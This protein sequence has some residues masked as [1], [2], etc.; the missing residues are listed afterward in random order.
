MATKIGSASLV[1]P[2]NNV[3]IS[4]ENSIIIIIIVISS[5]ILLSVYLQQ[6]DDCLGVL[7]AGQRLLSILPVGSY[8]WV[9]AIDG[10]ILICDAEVRPLFTWTFP[11]PPD[12]YSFPGRQ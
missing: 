4:E 11:P 10:T 12:T 2:P 8:V 1:F 7:G 6:S 3:D 5:V 9:G